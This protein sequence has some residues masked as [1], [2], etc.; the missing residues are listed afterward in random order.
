MSEF[1]GQ[2]EELFNEVRMMVTS[3]RKNDAIELLQAN[4]EA[5]KEQMETGA[6]A[7][8]QAAVLDVVALG[9]IRLLTV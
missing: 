4:F 8:E 5:V 2:L 3:G 1:E 7:I 9:C 6:I